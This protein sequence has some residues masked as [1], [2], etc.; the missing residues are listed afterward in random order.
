MAIYAA[1][2]PW[3]LVFTPSTGDP[4]RIVAG[5]P[6]ALR[7]ALDA[8]AAGMAGIVLPEDPSE[9]ASLER[10][11]DD[12]R[13]RLPLLERAPAGASTIAVPPNWLVHRQLLRQVVT[14]G[15]LLEGG[16][17]ARLEPAGPQH[18]DLSR[19]PL[20][21]DVPFSFEPIE[22]TDAASA[23]RAEGHAFR[24]LRKPQDGWTARW[25]NRYLSLPLSRLLVR[26][27]LTPNQ[28]SVGILAIGLC[29]AYLASR[30]DYASMAWGAFL[31][32]MQSVLDG[33]DGEMSRITHRGSLTGEWLDTVGDDLTNYSFYFGA[34]WGLFQATGWTPYLAAGLV[35]VSCGF[36]AS[37]LEYRYLVRIGSGDL[38][39]YPLSAGEG[40]SKLMAAIQPLFKRDTFVFLTFLAALAGWLG[41]MLIVFAAGAVGVLVNVLKTEL[42]LAR[43]QRGGT[44]VT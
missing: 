11:L 41:P 7:L 21:P 6:L 28:V 2:D 42:R 15:P 35:V 12:A 26:T 20:R 24:A 17:P 1:V 23:R 30:G 40:Q 33:C 43:E 4:A 8:G 10:L 31:F 38:L 13:L 44:P 27:P 16:A 39:K 14:G 36:I 32:Q 18:V 25:L 5:L 9:R 3:L 34:A 37:G 22:V 29:G 19:R